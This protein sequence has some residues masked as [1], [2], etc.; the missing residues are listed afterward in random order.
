MELA[1]TSSRDRA[2]VAGRKSPQRSRIAN[3]SA[4]LDGIDGRSAKARRFRDVLAEIVS[5]LGGADRLSEGQRQIARRC[6]ML[7]VDASASKHEASRVSRSTSK[8]TGSSPTVLAALPASR[9]E[10]RRPERHAVSR[11]IRRARGRRGTGCMKPT[12]TIRKALADPGL[13]G[14]VLAGESWPRGARS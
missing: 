8:H 10:A 6:A 1:A 13:L 14:N 9:L 5:D 4:L 11:G 7:S 3:G 12:I 2:A